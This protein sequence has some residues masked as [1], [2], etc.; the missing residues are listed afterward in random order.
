[1][2]VSLRGVPVLLEAVGRVLGLS[3]LDRSASELQDV[4][5]PLDAATNV[6]SF[7]EEVVGLR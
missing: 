3:D 6:L 5:V 4:Y 7:A 2:P 1:M